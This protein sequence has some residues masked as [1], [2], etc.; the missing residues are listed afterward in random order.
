MSI[1]K[2]QTKETKKSRDF[3][4]AYIGAA[5]AVIAAVIA[6]LATLVPSLISHVK[7]APD[8]LSV[9]SVK[10]ATV[11][12]K[13][14][15]EVV[16]LNE[17]EVSQPLTSLNFEL[18]QPSQF[19]VVGWQTYSIQATTELSSGEIRGTVRNGGDKRVSHTISGSIRRDVSG[20]WHL[21]LNV[22]TQ[23]EVPSKK[24]EW[25]LIT[26]PSGVQVGNGQNLD[27]FLANR[28]HVDISVSATYA[29]RREAKYEGD[30]IF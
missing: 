2:P 6:A 16:V 19:N 7:K 12:S 18:W 21:T 25:I 30:I 1:H 5:G 26:L 29:N 13:P 17:S 28:G 8:D 4:I 11:S 22:P 27:A 3:R 24:P 15:L 9:V 23:E 20:A 10:S 14:A